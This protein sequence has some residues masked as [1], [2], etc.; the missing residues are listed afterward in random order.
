M[1]RLSI[2]S[3]GL[4][5]T[6]VPFSVKAD[7]IVDIKSRGETVRILVIS[8]A[9]VEPVVVTVLFS[10][11]GGVLKITK[12]PFG[13]VIKQGRDNFL[14]RSSKYFRN[15]GF[16]TVAIDGPSDEPGNLYGFRG[17]KDHAKDVAAV[18][19]YLR[20]KFGLP[21][22]L[23]G[24]SRGTNSVAN[25]AVRLQGAKGPD[26]IALTATM[27]ENSSAGDQVLEYSLG[28]IRL[29]VVI[30]HHRA[31]FCRV[32][33]PENVDVLVRRLKNAKVSPVL[34]YEG[35]E[36]KGPECEPFHYHGFPGQE[37]RVVDDI[38]AAIKKTL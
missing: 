18:I 26:G 31:D 13:A 10:G 23:V 2:F 36:P 33:P 20:K 15:N 32:T 8:P 24:T 38:A 22:W 21:V 35:G 37:E 25:A 1:F 12:S 28:E 7:G 29:P 4:W 27:T 11:G 34:W 9:D 30:A 6:L 14:I 16:V 17:T 19:A 5:L 3:V